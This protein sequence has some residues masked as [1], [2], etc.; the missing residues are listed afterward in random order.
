MARKR[1]VSGRSRGKTI[2]GELRLQAE[3]ITK[4]LNQL[5]KA[6]EYGKLKAQKDFIR[7]TQTNRYVSIKRAVRSK[8][9]RVVVEKI[10]KSIAEQ[11]L[12]DKEFKTFLKSKVTT[13]IGIQRARAKQRASLTK[14]LKGIKGEDVSDEEVDRFIEMAEYADSEGQDSIIEKIGKSEFFALV[15][16]AKEQGAGVPQ[17]IDMLNN[18]VTINNDYMRKQAEE[19]YNRYVA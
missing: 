6:G 14:T 15:T 13:P 18:Y 3:K 8:R 17:W 9:R 10:Q 16:D 1:S 5:E 2:E 19:L 11:R 12:I 4:R 7:F